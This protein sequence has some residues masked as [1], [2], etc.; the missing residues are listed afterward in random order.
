MTDERPDPADGA[1]EAPSTPEPAPAQHPVSA[2]LTPALSSTILATLEHQG[3][4]AFVVRSPDQRA[5]LEHLRFEQNFEYLKDV[6]AIDFLGRDTVERF[7]LVYV[8]HRLTDHLTIRVH[9]WLSEEA[10]EAPSVVDLWD[11][12]RWGERETHD[13]FGI[14][15]DG[16]PDLRRLLMPED[17]PAFP[18]LKD[19]PLK[20][21][22]ERRQFPYL[23]PRGGEMVEGAP[24]PYPVTI[25][26]GMHTPDY[27]EEVRR[28]SRPKGE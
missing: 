16:N 27:I 17:Y 25:G 23:Q 5:L 2:A 3:Q 28:E 8:L 12:A 4:T 19:Y 24:P 20:G 14:V 9:A 13:M 15:F 1:E 21:R 18:L 22:G 7:Q 10:D 26:R 6:T 11:L